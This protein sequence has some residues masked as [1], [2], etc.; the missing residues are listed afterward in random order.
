MKQLDAGLV[1]DKVWHVEGDRFEGTLF[2]DG[3]NRFPGRALIFVGGSD[4]SYPFLR[5]VAHRFADEGISALAL[6]Y[7]KE[8]GLPQALC[9]I[10]VEYVEEAAKALGAEG[11]ERLGIW[12]ISYGSIY[13]LLSG[14]CLPDLISA[15]VAVAPSDACC[16]GMAGT[17][18][19]A[20]ASL[21]TF[22]GKDI[23]WM[24][25][26]FSFWHVAADTLRRGSL[27]MHT[28][29]RNK[30]RA[31]EAAFLPVERIKGPILFQTPAHDDMWDSEGSSASMMERLDRAGFA[32]PA[33]RLVY[34][35]AS[36]FLVPVKSRFTRIFKEE[37]KHPAE[38]WDSDIR[39]MED[40]LDFLEES[41]S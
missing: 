33:K 39:S 34:E 41:W 28:C 21:F 9:Q 38:C 8:P 25:L 27:S 32:Y 17:Y 18:K 30:D 12:G 13:A 20:D 14:I 29:Y 24:P 40:A 3:K 36:H 11:Y 37:R 35:H 22:R 26:E 16:E 15:V 7:W 6:A 23:P 31:P 5:A 10:P 19:L 1:P 2:K 4:G